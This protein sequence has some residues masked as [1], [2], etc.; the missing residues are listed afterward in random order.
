MN[1]VTP[2]RSA[3]LLLLEQLS[4]PRADQQLFFLQVL[5][6]FAEFQN[7]VIKERAVARIWKL[8]GF[9]TGDFWEEVRRQ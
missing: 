2:A 5:L 4:A 3:V 8:F 1:V 7:H 9:L 6:H